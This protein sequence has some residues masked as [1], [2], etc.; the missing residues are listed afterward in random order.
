MKRSR[1]YAACL[2]NNSIRA[3]SCNK[4]RAD[5]IFKA[6]DTLLISIA[7]HSNVK[8]ATMF[9]FF[10]YFLFIF[11]VIFNLICFDL[12]CSVFKGKG[13]GEI[14]ETFQH[15]CLRMTGAMQYHKTRSR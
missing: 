13:A 4:C 9:L 6:R 3:I 10:F 7:K 14:S 12:L 8:I 2:L 15:F 5:A 1:D 11:A